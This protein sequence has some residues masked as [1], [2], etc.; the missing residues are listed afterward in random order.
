MIKCI[1]ISQTT[2]AYSGYVPRLA[3]SSTSIFQI[4]SLL[5]AI[6]EWRKHYR[7]IY[8][9]PGALISTAIRELLDVC[10]YIK[11]AKF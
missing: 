7:Y 4:L 8:K 10:I 5:L 1:V 9:L 3:A 11:S 2:V 6:G